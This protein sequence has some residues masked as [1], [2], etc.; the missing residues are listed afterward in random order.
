[1]DE[2]KTSKKVLLCCAAGMSSSIM[3]KALRDAAKKQNA[4]FVFSA[5]DTGRV[6]DY[7]HLV[8]Y[9]LI[10]PQIDFEYEDIQKIAKPY[11]V[12]VM[13]IDADSYGHMY[14]EKLLFKI[15][16]YDLLIKEEEEMD[17]LSKG[18]EKHLLPFASKLGSNKVLKIIR[19][20]MSAT[21]A[22]LIL[23]S[24]SILLTNFPHE[25]IANFLAPSNDFFNT[26]YAY[27]SGMM[28][29][30]T[31]ATIAYYASVE[32]K[33]VSII[34]V[35]TSVAAFLITQSTIVDGYPSLNVDGLGVSGLM[36]GIL[37]SIITVK[38]IQ[39]FQEKKI[40]IKMPEGVP[41]AITE[42]FLSLLPAIAVLGM[43]TLITVVI[44]FNLNETI[45]YLLS[46][47]SKFLN[48]LPG[49]MLYHMLC[50]TV[51][52]LGINSAVVIGVFQV[53][54][55]SNSLAN[56]AAY[57]AGK[58]VEF[59]ATNSVDT[60]IWAGGT[61]A[62]IGLVLLMAFRSKSKMMKT[63]GRMSLGPGI[64]NIN[65]PVIF[66]TPIAFNPIF[67][68]PFILTPGLIAGITYALM[69]NGIISMPIIG[70]VPWTI[71]PVFVGYAMSGGDLRT[72]LW[73]AMIIVLSLVIYYPFFKIADKQYLEQELKAEM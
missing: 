39:L 28:G 21:V 2:E 50:A 65:E 61:G 45:M 17:R 9:I 46:P 47:L 53:F 23:G 25:G 32:Y 5:V 31:T 12:K 48:T 34:S 38:I 27:T 6:K 52:F 11:G 69:S 19:D 24:I 49:Y 67:L 68:V 57:A 13:V 60:M 58:T 8:D 4:S 20:G 26:I 54:L 36:T 44:G 30:I 14:G 72:T 63:L 16:H 59:V 43:F 7:I 40:A 42:S 51:F 73:S 55:T 70:N 15:Q 29:L 37:V 10:A 35:I 66:G 71:P 3:V 64:F 62:T 22:L 1:M 41:E 18:L 33:T 56:E